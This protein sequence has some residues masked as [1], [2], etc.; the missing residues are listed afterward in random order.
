MCVCNFCTMRRRVIRTMKSGSHQQKNKLINELADLYWSTDAELDY[1][2]AVANGSWP[3]AVEILERR[4][5]DARKKR[6]PPPEDGGGAP[7]PS[8]SATA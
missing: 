1:E 3:T 4:L 5:E 2:T 8:P 7:S 6:N